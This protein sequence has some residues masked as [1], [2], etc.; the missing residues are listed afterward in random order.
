MA[1][2]SA[3]L[4]A[5]LSVL[6]TAERM[7]L[8]GRIAYAAIGALAAGV[9]L[10]AVI[11]PGALYFRRLATNGHATIGR[12]TRL[13]LEQH[14][15]FVYEFEANNRTYSGRE[16]FALHRVGVG[17]PVPVTYLELTRLRRQ[18]RYAA[19]VAAACCFSK[20]IGLT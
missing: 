16:S 3:A 8:K 4:A 13:T 12:V 5:D 14:Y 2:R 11:A 18:S 17:S 6:R 10:A 9:L 20:S 7:R 1:R 15:T 19:T